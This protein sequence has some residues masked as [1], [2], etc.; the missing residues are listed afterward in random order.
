MLFRSSFVHTLTFSLLLLGSSAF[1][2]CEKKPIVVDASA[3]GTKSIPLRGD[4]SATG[5]VSKRL[6]VKGQDI[7]LGT[8]AKVFE[9]WVLRKNPKPDDKGFRILGHYDVNTQAEGL[10]LPR[11]AA[12]VYFLCALEGFPGKWPIPSKAF[13]LDAGL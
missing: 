8:R 12:N 4:R 7:V 2:A 1:F 10:A 6:S 5:V 3:A 13:E 9:T 11:G